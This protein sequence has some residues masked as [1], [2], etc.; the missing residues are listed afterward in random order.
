MEFQQ[1]HIMRGANEQKVKQ[2]EDLRS[3]LQQT[4]LLDDIETAEK[5]ES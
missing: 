5:E 2:Y 4:M 3:Q 1:K